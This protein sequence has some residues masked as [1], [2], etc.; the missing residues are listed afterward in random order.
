MSVGSADTIAFTRANS[1]A[2]IASMKAALL[3]VVSGMLRSYPV[4]A[5]AAGL[6]ACATSLVVQTFRSAVIIAVVLFAGGAEAQ[7]DA[8]ASHERPPL[9]AWFTV[10]PLGGLPVTASV[11]PLLTTVPDVIGDRIDTG[12]LSAGSP[13]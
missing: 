12:G 6:K 3:E 8:P 1:P 10:E 4:H 5:A 13:A 9:G 11:F 7:S 2:L